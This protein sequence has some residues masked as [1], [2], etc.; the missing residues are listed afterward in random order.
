M[1]ASHVLRTACAPE[2]WDETELIPTSDEV[3][4][5]KDQR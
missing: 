5:Q 3:G 4:D 1:S 2:I